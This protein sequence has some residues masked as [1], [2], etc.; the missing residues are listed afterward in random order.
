MPGA[1]RSKSAKPISAALCLR[2]SAG[3]PTPLI[4]LLKAKVKPEFDSPVDRTVEAIFSRFSGLQFSSISGL[5]FGFCC[6][7]G[8]GSQRGRGLGFLVNCQLL[9]AC[10]Q[11]SSNYCL[12]SLE[13]NSLIYHLFAPRV[14]RKPCNKTRITSPLDFQPKNKTNSNPRCPSPAFGGTAGNSPVTFPSPG[15]PG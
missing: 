12:S 3:D 11:R 2:S 1:E 9:A 4:L 15:V 7:V 6:P 10:F 14:K 13:G 5:F 8:R